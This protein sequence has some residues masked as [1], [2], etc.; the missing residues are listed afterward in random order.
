MMC[1]RGRIETKRLSPRGIVRRQR[2]VDASSIDCVTV[3]PLGL[4]VDPEVH[5]ISTGSVGSAG[6]RA[7]RA[8]P[9]EMDRSIP[10]DAAAGISPA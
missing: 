10:D 8:A 9:P 7:A 3:T 6:S 2:T 5:R 1:D 4:P